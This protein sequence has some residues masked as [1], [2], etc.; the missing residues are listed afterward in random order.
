MMS[1]QERGTE[2]RKE[3]LR[4]A[5]EAYFKG[6]KSKDFSVIPFDDDVSLRAPLCPGGVHRPVE[7]KDAVRAQWWQPLEP[8]L[9][10]LEVNVL[11]H[12]FNESLTCV[13]TEAEVTIRLPSCVLLTASTS[14]SRGR[15]PSR[16]TTST[17]AT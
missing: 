7:G 2:D 11:D 10:G 4:A 8:A 9:E 17:L 1:P 13:I 5:A 3:Q 16:R 12:Y 6:L 15:S 14:M